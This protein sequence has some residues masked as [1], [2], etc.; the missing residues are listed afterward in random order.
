MNLGRGAACLAAVCVFVPTAAQAALWAADPSLELTSAANDNYGLAFD[1][2]NR[3]GLAS[4][5]GG[6]VASRETQTQATR[7]NANL[8]G[9]RLRGD[10]HQDEWQDS[11]TLSHTLKG[12]VDTF[13]VDAKTARDQ[14][15]Q[16]PAGSA[17]LLLGRGLQR[18]TSGDARWEHGLTERLGATGTLAIVRTRYSASLVGARDY[19]DGSG[20]ASL[21]YLLDERDSMNVA[22]AH[23][24][25][26]SLDDRVRSMTDS[27]SVGG[28]RALSE[29]SN[30]S[31]SVGAFRQRTGVLQAVLACPAGT[32]TCDTPRVVAQVG[33]Q[34]R[35]GAQ[36]NA[37]Y[38]GRLDERTRVNA[39]AARQQEP[40]G[41][42]VTVLDDTLRAGVDRAV[43]ETLTGQLNYTRSSSRY[44]GLAGGAAARLQT[45]AVVMS[46]QLS[47]QL[48]LRATADYKRSTQAFDGLHAHSASVALT[49]RYEWQR[50]DARH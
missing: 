4:M 25:Y 46:Q 21:R 45:L 22:V 31:V 28:A 16:S 11:L 24:D 9:L 20:S 26:R 6:L 23:Q 32:A 41:S 19:Q 40:S 34:A 27:L 43:S 38:D 7:L 30:A 14:T 42:G 15:L 47:P 5:T 10:L 18:V 17:D 37:S 29:T 1:R 12:P 36:Y 8:V 13:S 39:S 3:V 35:W 48:S 33:R 2:R 50:L 49:L 44:Q